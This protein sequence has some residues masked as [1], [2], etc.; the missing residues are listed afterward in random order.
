MMEI[1]R[2]R[3]KTG[4]IMATLFLIGI[5]VSLYQIYRLPQNMMVADGYHPALSNVYV[6]LGIT[7]LI[8]AVTIWSALH[9]RNEIIVFRDKQAD[10]KTN[11]DQATS[12][13]QSTI[14]LESV[15]ESISA[16]SNAKDVLQNGL[17]AVCKLLDA[18]QGAAYLFEEKDGKRRIEL[19]SGYALSLSENTVIAYDLG[20]GLIGQAAASGKTLYIDDVPTGYVKI[21]S[22]LG[23]ASPKYLLIV[24][25]KVNEKVIG[26]IEIASFSPV[27]EDQRK[28]VEESAQLIAQKVSGK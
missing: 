19:K 17:Q 13:Q 6:I 16:T 23:M 27:S 12:G 18:G 20:E 8:G 26:V 1:L 2:D 4:L 22:G 9:N 15:K 14:S 10:D 24:P 25:V 28:F 21:V 11:R 3:Y 5:L 7:F